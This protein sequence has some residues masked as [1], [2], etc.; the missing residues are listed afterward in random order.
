MRVLII[1]SWY[2]TEDKPNNGIFFKEQARALIECGVEVC[3]IYPDLRFKLKRLRRG[4][5]KNYEAEFPTYI[6]R[7]RTFT[8]GYE[9]GRWPQILKMLEKLYEVA[10]SE[11]GEFDIVHLHSARLG[12]EVVKLCHEHNLPL[13]Y[14]EHYS[15]FLK[16]MDD[17]LKYQFET[18]LKGCD[19]PIAVSEDLK[20]RM[21]S[22]RPDTLFIPNMVDTDQFKIMPN[23]D[24][25][26][27]FVFA[28]VGNLVSIKGFDILIEAFAKAKDKIPRA[29][30]NIAG[31]GEEEEHLKK[32]IVDLKLSDRVF[33]TGYLSRKLAPKFYNECDCYVCSSNFETFGVSMIEALAC[34]KPIIATRCGGPASIVNKNNGMLITTGNVYAMERALKLMYRQAKNYYPYALR[35][36]C[37][38]RFGKKYVCQRIVQLYAH[39]LSD[40]QVEDENQQQMIELEQKIEKQI[41]EQSKQD[42]LTKTIINK[43][44]NIEIVEAPIVPVASVVAV[45][46]EEKAKQTKKNKKN[47]I[48]HELPLKIET[49]DLEKTPKEEMNIKNNNKHKNK[50]SLFSKHKNDKKTDQKQ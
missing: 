14:T 18:T 6:Y 48:K 2:E 11:V 33:L 1:P 32:L 26:P 22:L 19:C 25:R 36:D 50:L 49:I 8:P 47:R 35:E 37:I 45:V 4:I 29:I 12:S 24:I 16:P 21:V 20:A 27:G 34:G 42:I 9:R 28:S 3:V 7:K 10:V 30:L 40:R 38:K 15:G 43:Q 44:S 31:S 17:D 46:K 41:E 23:I 13:V 5:F 39:V